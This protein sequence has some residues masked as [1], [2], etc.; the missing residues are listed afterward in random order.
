MSNYWNDNY[1]TNGLPTLNYGNQNNGSFSQQFG[2]QNTFVG[3]PNVTNTTVEDQKRLKK[4]KSKQFWNAATDRETGQYIAGSAGVTQAVGQ[5]IVGESYNPNLNMHR[6]GAK[7]MF[8]LSLTKNLGAINPI[9]GGIGFF[10]DV[11][12]NLFGMGQYQDTY[13]AAEQQWKNREESRRRNM[14]MGNDYTASTM[15]GGGFPGG[16]ARAKYGGSFDDETIEIEP[17]EA[18]LTK[19]KDGKYKKYLETGGGVERHENNGFKTKAPKGAY[20]FPAQYLKDINRY[21]ETENWSAI[22]K[23]KNQMMIESTAASMAN[24]PY[25]NQSPAQ[26]KLN[27][28]V[29]G[30]AE[31]VIEEGAV[32]GEETFTGRYGGQIPAWKGGGL[33]Y[34]SG[35]QIVRPERWEDFLYSIKTNEKPQYRDLTTEGMGNIN[36]LEEVMYQ[37]IFKEQKK[38]EWERK[39]THKMRY[40]GKVQQY[41]MGGMVSQQNPY[42]SGMYNQMPNQ[43]PA[44][45][46][47]KGGMV[48]PKDPP[49]KK[50]LYD[51]RYHKRDQKFLERQMKR[52][53]RQDKKMGKTYLGWHEREDKY[54]DVNQRDYYKQTDGSSLFMQSGRPST[55]SQDRLNDNV[56]MPGMRNVFSKDVYDNTIYESKT[57]TT[58]DQYNTVPFV[59]YGSDFCA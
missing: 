19:G 42:M 38:N 50:G 34:S 24:L 3:G 10:G 33:D 45:T 22:D 15:G 6:P 44:Q 9:F 25:S 55:F 47:E 48:G 41:N 31:Q 20:V 51:V 12:K 28:M 11:G 14:L 54:K 40:G 35:R 37:D 59:E 53:E 52:S 32:G 7:E 27:E 18:I 30:S 57:Q 43:I 46:Y 36:E 49:K 23:L 56:I 5:G 2:N 58:A 17:Y 13:A 39:N 16:Y 21:L 8:D 26:Q 4:E 1:Q 29:K